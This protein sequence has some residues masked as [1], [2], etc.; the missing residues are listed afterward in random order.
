[1]LPVKMG[2]IETDGVEVDSRLEVL[3]IPE[4]AGHAS[5]FLNLAIEPLA[6]RASHTGC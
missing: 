6:H 2:S 4:A 3:D 5:D 1:M